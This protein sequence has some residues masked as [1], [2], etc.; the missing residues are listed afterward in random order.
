MALR[1]ALGGLSLSLSLS[2]RLRRVDRNIYTYV[3][4]EIRAV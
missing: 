3:K 4:G 1:C 2:A